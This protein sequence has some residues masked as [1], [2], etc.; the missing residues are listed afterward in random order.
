MKKFRTVCAD[1]PWQFRDQGS[2]ISPN[3]KEKH[4]RVQ[5][6]HEICKA[7]KSVWHRILD[8]AFLFLWCPN[9][10]VLEGT[11]ANVCHSWGFTPKQLIP[12]VKIGKT[13]GRPIIGM[14]HYTR[15]CTE[16]L[17]LAVR[18]KPDVKRNDVPGVLHAVRTQHSA[19]PDESYEL[20]ESLCPGPYLELYARR[21]F[22]KKWTAWGDQLDGTVL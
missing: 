9:V 21:Q 11:A 1:P 17:V 3:H 8:D 4:Y 10:L 2:R 19:K 22:S 14:G 6:I 7:G 5:P 18:G 20:I 16:M 15:V 13:T 12:W